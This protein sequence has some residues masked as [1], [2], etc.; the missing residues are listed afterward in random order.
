MA[1]DF[2]PNFTTFIKYRDKLF[3]AAI[4]GIG[5]VSSDYKTSKVIYSEKPN[6]LWGAFFH[7]IIFNNHIF[8]IPRNA[9]KLYVLNPENGN[10][11]KVLLP[12]FSSGEV[13]I[14]Y[15]SGKNLLLYGTET[16]IKYRIDDSF[17]VE[18]IDKGEGKFK[19][20]YQFSSYDTYLYLVDFN[21]ALIGR[22]NKKDDDLEIVNFQDGQINCVG[23]YRENIYVLDEDG[24]IHV[25]SALDKELQKVIKT[26]YKS[27]YCKLYFDGKFMYIMPYS[28]DVITKI[29]LDNTDKVENIKIRRDCDERNMFWNM[30][31]DGNNICMTEKKVD[32][33]KYKIDCFGYDFFNGDTIEFPLDM[34]IRAYFL[35]EENA[36]ILISENNMHGLNEFIAF[37][38][39]G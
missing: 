34:M 33:W 38:E 31:S 5:F 4:H 39:Q 13:L 16:Q 14:P 12:G 11:L 36:D 9:E 18:L 8:F 32:S 10:V 27:K 29:K 28:D 2:R 3:Y 24:N 15:I 35:N 30:L 19:W 7:A 1:V 20:R 17:D 25:L 6:E 26:G 23:E 37:V 21:N 22:I